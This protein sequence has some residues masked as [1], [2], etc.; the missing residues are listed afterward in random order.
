MPPFRRAPLEGRLEPKEPPPDRMRPASALL[1][2]ILPLSLLAS[3]VPLAPASAAQKRD[4]IVTVEGKRVAVDEVLA[5]SFP[6]VRYKLGGAEKAIPAS[7][8][9]RIEYRDEPPAL[10]QARGKREAGDPDAALRAYALAKETAGARPWLAE[11]VAFETADA[12]EQWG[13]LDVRRTTEAAE[14]YAKFAEAYPS[15]RRLPDALL[16]RARCLRTLKQFDPAAALFDEV[17]KRGT[18]LGEAVELEAVY[19]RAVTMLAA[20]RAGEARGGLKALEGRIVGMNAGGAAHAPLLARARLAQGDCILAA[21]DPEEARAHFRRLSAEAGA[22]ARLRYG[23]RAGEGEAL[24]AQGKVR[25]ALLAFAEVIALEPAGLPG[26]PRATYLAGEC[27]RR[28]VGLEP[29][30]ERTAAQ[31]FKEVADLFPASPWAARAKAALGTIPGT[32]KAEKKP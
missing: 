30:A 10:R 32:E 22:D 26:T 1:P 6:E 16:G 12:L 15:S 27:Y 24:L 14:A 29:D 5:D 20:G 18:S 17:A 4:F 8:V 13:A 31:Y 21:G 9:V 3:A 2:R 7:Q 28:L 11:T 23:A 19:E 25:E